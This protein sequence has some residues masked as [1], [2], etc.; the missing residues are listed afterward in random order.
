MTV[1][2]AQATHR[3]TGNEKAQAGVNRSDLDLRIERVRGIEPPSLAWEARALPLSYTRVERPGRYS[4]RTRA[5]NVG[6]RPPDTEH[7]SR[8]DHPR[9]EP[10]HARS[11]P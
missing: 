6:R 11:H 2:Y 7:T 4:P 1:A 9:Q 10:V 5:R 3:L 8:P